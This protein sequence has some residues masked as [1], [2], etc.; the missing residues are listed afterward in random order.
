MDGLAAQ[1]MTLGSRIWRAVVTIDSK[2]LFVCVGAATGEGV[3]L[4]GCRMAVAQWLLTRVENKSQIDQN[5]DFFH[6]PCFLG[7]T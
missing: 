6:P 5:C 2:Q 1:R 4:L 3:N 7:L